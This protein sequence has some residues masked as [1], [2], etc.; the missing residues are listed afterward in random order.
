MTPTE[1]IIPGFDIRD[2]LVY[3]AKDQP[4]YI[5]LPAW[6]GDDGRVVTRWKLSWKE[7]LQVL[8]GGSIWLSVLTLKHPLQPVKLE[9]QC[10]L[11]GFYGEDKEI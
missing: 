7:R 4:E 5:T 2:E 9:T 11:F 1:E 6:R 10:P 8:L 3:F